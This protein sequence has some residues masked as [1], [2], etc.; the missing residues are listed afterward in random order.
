M[1][2]L[3]QQFED[4]AARAPD[5]VALTFEGRHLSYGEL[6][7]RANQLAW[8]LRDA[9]IGAGTL[10][11]L[12]LSPGFDLIVGMLAVLKAGGAYLPLDSDQPD[13]RIEHLLGLAELYNQP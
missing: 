6:N 10:V 8:A 2:F 12:H 7:E 13:Q 4:Q 1:S 5:R 11:G 9:G 3:H